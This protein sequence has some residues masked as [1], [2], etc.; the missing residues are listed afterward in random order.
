MPPA[1]L[2]GDMIEET[3][4]AARRVAAFSRSLVDPG[5]YY[6]HGYGSLSFAEMIDGTIW[7]QPIGQYQLV[8]L[9]PLV[10]LAPDA[11]AL[12]DPL[13][14]RKWLTLKGWREACGSPAP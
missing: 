8:G 1:T 6:A 3:S 11:A 4:D 5:V 10:E 13:A 12:H 14:Y 2:E 9:I 7:T